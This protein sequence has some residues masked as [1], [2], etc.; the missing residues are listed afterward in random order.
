MTGL[1]EALNISSSPYINAA[2]SVLVFIVIAKVVD[3]FIDKVLRRFARFT[4]SAADDRIIDI[5]HRP[6]YYTIILVGILLAISYLEPPRKVVFYSNGIVHSIITV[7]WAVTL[8]RAV[9][10]VI[11]STVYRVSDVTGLG[12]DLVPLFENVTKIAIFAA[13][14]M[15]IFS[16]WEINITPLMASAGIVGAGVAIA[17]KDTISNLF[18]GI[19][20]YVD[21]PFKIGD[22]IV[23][24]RGERG[25]V[26]AIGLRSTRIKTRD[27][28]LISVPNSIIASSKIINESAPIPKFRV[29]V[30]VG[31]AYGSDIDLV[32][33]TLTGI[34]AGN[35]NVLSE[36]EP[37]VRFRSFGD[38]A[39]MFELLCWAREPALRGF[40]IHELNRAIFHRFKELGIVIPFPQR[41]VH[42][43]HE[44]PPPDDSGKD[45]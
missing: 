3:V 12:R 42:V 33:N 18:G 2:L 29:R 37:R 41:D 31:V 43:Y 28:I 22:Y 19:S 34:A 5:V 4:K 23:L 45:G 44:S 26:V 21:K 40:T 13:V 8:A 7:L 30:P 1:I 17:A 10:A 39:L 32:E 36:P 15:V 14:I 38:S 20:V 24:D 9:N 25:E 11:E 16:I 35:D 6:V 27:D